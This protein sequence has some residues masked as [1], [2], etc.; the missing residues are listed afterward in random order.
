MFAYI[1]PRFLYIKIIGF[2]GIERISTGTVPVY[3]FWTAG[4]AIAITFH[5]QVPKVGT[6]FIF[7]VII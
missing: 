4:T 6:E 7:I 1:I 3:R 2:T 5:I